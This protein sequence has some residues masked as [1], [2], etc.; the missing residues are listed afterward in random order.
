MWNFAIAIYRWREHF[1]ASIGALAPQSVQSPSWLTKLD[2]FT[3]LIGWEI[4]FVGVI[5]GLMALRQRTRHRR[6]KVRPV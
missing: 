1:M 4:L 5:A 2:D 6:L 3:V